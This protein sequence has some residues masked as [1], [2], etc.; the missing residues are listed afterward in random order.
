MD[1]FDQVEKMRQRSLLSVRANSRKEA[2]LHKHEQKQ[3]HDCD[4]TSNSFAMLEVQ[5]EK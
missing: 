1:Y 3:S 5:E 2:C 4:T